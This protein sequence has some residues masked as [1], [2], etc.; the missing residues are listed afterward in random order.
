VGGTVIWIVVVAAY[1]VAYPAFAWT[2]YDLRRFPRQLWSGFGSPHPWRRAT[3]ITYVLG[4][5]PVC[6][7]ALAWRSSRTRAELR[8]AGHRAKPR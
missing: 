1:L 5:L 8:E 4:G 7:T 6:L 3:V 2:L